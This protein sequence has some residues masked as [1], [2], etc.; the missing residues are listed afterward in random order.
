M[1]SKSCFIISSIGKINSPEREDADEKFD[2]V[3]EPVLR[4]LGYDPI[5]RADKL[6]VRIQSLMILLNML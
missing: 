1:L 5:I 2:L 4:D 6:V 3:F